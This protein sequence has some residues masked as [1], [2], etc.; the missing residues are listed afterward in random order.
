MAFCNVLHNYI[1]ELSG[2]SLLME[3][4]DSMITDFMLIGDIR[5]QPGFYYPEI[6]SDTSLPSAL[7]YT[8]S[9]HDYAVNNWRE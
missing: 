6:Q 8:L 3:S 2:L 7:L 1:P 4:T 5:I 9:Q